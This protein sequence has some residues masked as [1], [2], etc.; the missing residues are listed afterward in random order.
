MAKI[1]I[2][3]RTEWINNAGRIQVYLDGQKIGYIYAGETKE[4]EVT[5]G[6]HKLQAKIDWCG[7]KVFLFTINEN[8]TKVLRLSG[9]KNSK[10]LL[11]ITAGI[12]AMHF[13]LK[14]TLKI[15]FFIWLI[16]P[17]FLILVYYFTIGR[18]NYLI[19]REN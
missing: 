16:I 2:T 14:H 19:I 9:F 11:G 12:I 10:Y 5:G 1:E 4:F 18:N 15:D 7:S 13:L 17:T 8:E 6:N 3:R